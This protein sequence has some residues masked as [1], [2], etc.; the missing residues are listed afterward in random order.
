MK[1][2]ANVQLWSRWLAFQVV[3]FAAVMGAG[4]GHNWPGVGAA[5]LFLT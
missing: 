5:L 3:W 1:R 4:R 2:Y